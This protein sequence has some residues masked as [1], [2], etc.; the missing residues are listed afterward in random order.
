VENRY[1][2]GIA[3]QLFNSINRAGRTYSRRVC[4]RVNNAF[5]ENEVRLPLLIT[6]G[7][8][9]SGDEHGWKLEDNEMRSRLSRL[10]KSPTRT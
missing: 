5:R 3:F 2:I 6:A 7:I 10:R 9:D 1:K 8:K 4:F